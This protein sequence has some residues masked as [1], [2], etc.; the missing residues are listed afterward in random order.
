MFTY[1]RVDYSGRGELAERQQKL[2]A[3]LCKLKKVSDTV[4]QLCVR[5]VCV[6]RLIDK[7][8]LCRNYRQMTD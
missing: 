8:V 7:N 5:A 6:R 4:V 1:T 2:G 3:F